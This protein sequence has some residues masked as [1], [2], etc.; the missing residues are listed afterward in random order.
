MTETMMRICDVCGVTI[1][2]N[3]EYYD[4]Q[5]LKN[6]M[7]ARSPR[8]WQFCSGGCFHVWMGR[9]GSFEPKEITT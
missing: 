2:A 6:G 3:V 8:R 1:A 4:V 5:V 7:E 9:I